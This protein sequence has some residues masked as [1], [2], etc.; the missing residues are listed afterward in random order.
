MPTT[1]RIRLPLAMSTR[2]LCTNGYFGASEPT[3]AAETISRDAK[4]LSYVCTG[5][6]TRL[7]H[8]CQ[9]LGQHPSSLRRTYRVRFSPTVPR[10]R[11]ICR[12]VVDGEKKYIAQF[13]P[14]NWPWGG[15]TRKYS[16]SKRKL[17]RPRN[18][19]VF[20]NMRRKHYSVESFTER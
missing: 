7:P 17:R 4:F 1:R 5:S 8:D 18:E 13:A 19:P 6:Q 10:T 20:C 9:I 14:N 3:F 16:F 11:V 15:T 2:P 12:Q